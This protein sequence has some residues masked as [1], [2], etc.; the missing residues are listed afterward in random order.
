MLNK[1][2]Q[3]KITVFLSTAANC[4]TSAFKEQLG[5]SQQ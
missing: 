3:K 1:A 2:K 5:F 4:E